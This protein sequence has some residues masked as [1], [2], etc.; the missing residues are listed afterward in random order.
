MLF[1]LLIEFAQ[2][3]DQ[4]VMGYEDKSANPNDVCPLCFLSK[5][6]K[7]ESLSHIMLCNDSAHS[8]G[9]RQNG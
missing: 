5:N 6:L 2:V 1:K 7:Q 3:R 9:R 4:I 8:N